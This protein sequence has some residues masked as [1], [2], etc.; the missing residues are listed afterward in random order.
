MKK[1]DKTEYVCYTVFERMGVAMKSI[2]GKVRQFFSKER[3]VLI[4]LDEPVFV[5]VGD[6]CSFSLRKPQRSVPQNNLYHLFCAWCSKEL[7]KNGDM[8]TPE[9][10]HEAF[11]FTLLPNVIVTPNNKTVRIAGS[12]TDLSKEEF[13]AFMDKANM[14]AIQEWGLP[15]H[16]FWEE[17][18]HE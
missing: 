3:C 1:I 6:I 15:T 16:I 17:Y 13:T 7:C 14:V 12:T 5:K 2:R 18:K 9:G 4:E 11:K 8:I 10:V